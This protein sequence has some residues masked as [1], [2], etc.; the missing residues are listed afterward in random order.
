MMS[1]TVECVWDMS[2]FVQCVD[3]VLDG[4]EN[5]PPPH[6]QNWL[7]SDIGPTMDQRNDIHNYVGSALAQWWPNVITY[8]ITLDQRWSNDGPT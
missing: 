3:A 2:A 8:C 6:E 1:N 4:T 5:Y 7:A